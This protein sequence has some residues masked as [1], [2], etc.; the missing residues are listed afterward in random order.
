MPEIKKAAGIL[1][2]TGKKILLLKRNEEKKTEQNWSVP[3]GKF[4]KG[5][6]SWDAAFRET[7]EE[8]GHCPV[9]RIFGTIEDFSPKFQYTT[10]MMYVPK[11]FDCKLSNE[12]LDYNW[13][14]I[15]HLDKLNIHYKLAKKLKEI[16][17]NINKLNLEIKIS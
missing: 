4:N 8:I 2:T 13:F 5:E 17:K 15:K 7:I 12:H 16:N 14:Y 1:F 3:G 10:Y 9:G 11:T 6:T